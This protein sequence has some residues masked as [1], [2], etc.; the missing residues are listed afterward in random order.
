MKTISE[1]LRDLEVKAPSSTA[2]SWDNVG[3]L[4]GDPATE[5]SG[6]I[7]SVDLTEE[8]IEQAR[9]RGFKLIVNHHPCIFPK[10][11]GLSSVVAGERSSSNLVF[12]ALKQGI[13]VIAAHTNF[14]RCAL[15]VI[16]GISKG[17]GARPTGRLLEK[18]SGSCVKLVVFVPTA[19]VDAVR[20]A[21]CD[22]GAGQ[23][24][25]YDFCTFATEGRGTFRGGAGTQ[26]FVGKPG[27][28]ETVEELRLETILPRGLEK[29][30]LAALFRVHPYEEPAY[31]LIP[32]EQAPSGKGLARG[33][34]YGFV[35]ELEKPRPF[36]ELA[37]EIETLFETKGFLITGEPAPDRLIRRVAW[38]PGKGSSFVGAVI[39]AKCDLFFTGETGYHDALH[40]AKRG[41]VVMELGHRESE[42]FYLKV[43][44]GWMKDAGL[45]VVELNTKTQRISG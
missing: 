34:G 11:K 45:Q 31:D 37:A 38:S 6:A 15:E 43:M 24:G 39:A 5:T 21:I 9:A 26:P 33:L 40:A 13:S 12:E 22:A 3:L 30:V 29:A 42:R 8:A 20:Q 1:V 32:V 4:C 17:I 19:Q 35:G 7:V 36:R 2:E 27:E 18:A 44:S 28:L 10:Q 25:A 41:V 23:I 14:D 16:E